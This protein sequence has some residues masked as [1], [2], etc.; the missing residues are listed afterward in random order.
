MSPMEAGM[1]QFAQAALLRR[2]L[3][4]T[5]GATAIEYGLV[6]AGIGGTVAATIWKL[7]SQIKANLYDRLVTLF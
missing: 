4:D 7:G 6:A 2:F 5:S 1:V 3:Q